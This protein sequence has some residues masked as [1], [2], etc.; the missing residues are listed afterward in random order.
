MNAAR[1]NVED[2]KAEEAGSGK[3]KTM[4]TAV[5]VITECKAVTGRAAVNGIVAGKAVSRIGEWVVRAGKAAVNGKAAAGNATMKT[6]SHMV[7]ISGATG[8]NVPAACRARI[9]ADAAA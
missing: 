1:V 6:I 2:G 9:L 8:T 7:A 4:T 3:M 5:N